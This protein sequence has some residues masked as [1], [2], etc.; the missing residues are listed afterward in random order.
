M[1]LITTKVPV[2]HPARMNAVLQFDCCLVTR[3]EREMPQLQSA[4]GGAFL[5]CAA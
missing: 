4:L 1:I 2:P 3:S 5:G